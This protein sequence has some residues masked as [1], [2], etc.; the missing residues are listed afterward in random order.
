MKRT[1]GLFF[2][3]LLIIAGFKGKSQDSLA[4]YQVAIFTPLFLDSAFDE[5]ASYRYGKAFPKYINPGLEFYEGAELAIDSLNIEGVKLDI[6]VYDSR[7]IKNGIDSIVRSPEFDSIDLVIGH[8]NAKEARLLANAAAR[9]S[10]PVINATYPNDAGVTNN[11]NYIVLNSTLLT[12]CAAMYRFI[13]KNYALAPVVV[14]RKKG[15]QEDRLK[16]YFDDITKSTSSVPLKIKFVTLDNLFSPEDIKEH[17]EK[18][19]KTVCIAGS[20]DV[21]FGQLLTSQLASLYEDYPSVLFGMPTW[22]DL[23]DFSKPEYKNV[24]VFYTSPFYISDSNKLFANIIADYKSRFYS[25]PTDMFFRGYE[26]VY[27]FAHLLLLN[28]RNI[29][30]SLS[31]KRYKIF[32]DF[33]IQPV[34]NPKTNTLDYFENKKIYFIKKVNGAEIAVY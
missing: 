10:I 25:R 11:P 2:A 27:H 16:S 19:V 28:G 15:A 30:S 6:Y 14:F 3:I 9:K 5:T 33:D 31:D 21:N 8:V 17:L 24:E 22:W 4:R 32:T 34:L 13:Q 23:T 1:P 7:S 26:T 29:G 12:H 18:D 20:L